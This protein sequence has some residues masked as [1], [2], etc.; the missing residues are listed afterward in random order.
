VSFTVP[1]PSSDALTG[2]NFGR[3]LPNT[4]GRV[5]DKVILDAVLAGNV[6]DFLRTPVTVYVMSRTHRAEFQVL[7]DYLCIGTDK[8]FLRV[9]LYPSTAQQIAD[10][11]SATLPTK[12]LV[13][14][15][16]KQAAFLVSPRPMVSVR[17]TTAC[18]MEHN[19]L[20]ELQRAGRAGLM[21]GHKKDIVLTPKLLLPRSKGLAIYGWHGL[22]G[23]PL[24]GLNAS[25]HSAQYVDYSHGV[26]LIAR[27]VL[28][29]GTP[30][31]F[32]ELLQDPELSS[33][34][35]DEGPSS[36]LAYPAQ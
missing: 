15:I 2:T 20:I 21:A 8:D 1:P 6:P 34:V 19:L 35:S 7:P 10:A 33:L 32:Q 18:F 26:R 14:L 24:Q 4:P 31:D 23:K 22:S 28:V 25:D 13:D 36:F 12:L 17:E 5:R 29:D 9:P 30:M 27:E 3:A 16:W 11:F